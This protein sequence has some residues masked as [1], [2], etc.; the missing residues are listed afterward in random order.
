MEKSENENVVD[1]GFIMHLPVEI[2]YRIMSYTQL[3]WWINFVRTSKE[4]Y[5]RYGGGEGASSSLL[6]SSLSFRLDTAHA[7]S[8]AI[9]RHA[10]PH[11][12][13]GKLGR[14][15]KHA[16]RVELRGIEG[17]DD[18]LLR[19]FLS[20]CPSLSK[21]HLFNMPLIRGGI[22]IIPEEQND[23]ES[24]RKE[25]KETT[26]KDRTPS[27][28]QG[29]SLI[30]EESSHLQMTILNR[31]KEEP[32]VSALEEVVER[33]KE[34]TMRS[35]G[36]R[37]AFFSRLLTEHAK[38]QGASGFKR[39]LKRMESLNV[40]ST[41]IHSSFH[42]IPI[43]MPSLLHLYVDG[44]SKLDISTWN[45]FANTLE[46]ERKKK[47]E[48]PSL[49]ARSPSLESLPSSI[50]SRS[51][52]EDLK[53]PIPVFLGSSEPMRLVTFSAKTCPHLSDVAFTTII[54]YIGPTLEILSLRLNGLLRARSLQAIARY[55]ENLKELCIVDLSPLISSQDWSSLFNDDLLL[56]QQKY[57]TLL[58]GGGNENETSLQDPPRRFN[59]KK[60]TYLDVSFNINIDDSVVEQLTKGEGWKMDNLNISR[61]SISDLA[62]GMLANKYASTL[63][64]IDTS[65]CASLTRW[66]DLGRFEK[67][68]RLAST[69][70]PLLTDVNPYAQYDRKRI[71]GKEEKKKEGEGMRE[72]EREE[73]KEEEN[74]QLRLTVF[75]APIFA[76]KFIQ[77]YDLSFTMVT[78]EV[79]EKLVKEAK[80]VASVSVIGCSLLSDLS[81]VHIASLLHQND[82]SAP[83]FSFGI[84]MIPRMSTEAIRAFKETFLPSSLSFFSSFPNLPH[85]PLTSTSPFSVTPNSSIINA[86][87]GVRDGEEASA[88]SSSFSASSSSSSLSSTSSPLLKKDLTDVASMACAR[89]GHVQPR[90]TC[91]CSEFRSPSDRASSAIPH[92]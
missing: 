25:A 58:E 66:A 59:A 10:Q 67:L 38:G 56:Q 63:R 48:I 53:L 54:K 7:L 47:R 71:G 77:K 80:S 16:S 30:S 84:C 6:Y 74:N 79:I 15:V 27:S 92:R 91:Q 62:L 86:I 2:V 61:T 20:L 51:M 4:A 13:L 60:L 42:L 87:R 31:K 69:E 50:H 11:L 21:L 24:Q 3:I 55:C 8:N 88:S 65:G 35:I 41:S 76:P 78:D 36:V 39:G 70:C 57:G 82:F 43:A 26:K 29:E 23:T 64:Y 85:V 9:K 46:E 45:Q 22:G 72:E 68:L 90:M 14:Y 17:M 1:S 12:L 52:K 83:F 5:E 81:I 44:C 34:L 75:N 73:K 89:G 19:S 33:L 18:T 32:T 49:S 40:M 28:S 37:E